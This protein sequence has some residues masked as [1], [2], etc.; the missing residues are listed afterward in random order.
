MLDTYGARGAPPLENLIIW[1]PQCRKEDLWVEGLMTPEESIFRQRNYLKAFTK[2]L[3]Q[4][5]RF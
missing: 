1:P 2:L 4:G 5:E 3:A